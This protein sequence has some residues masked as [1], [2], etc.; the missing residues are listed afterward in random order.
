[1]MKI[2]VMGEVDVKSSLLKDGFDK[3]E[4]WYLDVFL[5]F[6]L[7]ELLGIKWCK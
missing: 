3:E 7:I 5:F 4:F 6:L 2:D 1:M